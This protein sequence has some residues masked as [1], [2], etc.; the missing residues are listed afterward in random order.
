MR[1]PSGTARVA[2]LASWRAISA[3]SPL[4]WLDVLEQTISN[5]ARTARHTSSIWRAMSSL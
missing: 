5:G 2:S 4:A 1:T 3:G